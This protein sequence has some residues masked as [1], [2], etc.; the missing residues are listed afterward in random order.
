M[1]R[2]FTGIQQ[3]LACLDPA[4]S[5]LPAQLSSYCICVEEAPAL[6]W[7]HGGSGRAVYLW[8][9]QTHREVWIKTARTNQDLYSRFNYFLETDATLHL[10]DALKLLQEER[11]YQKLSDPEQQQQQALSSRGQRGAALHVLP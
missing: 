10:D 1:Q 9:S 5:G 7:P 11:D 4:R 3:S 6:E 8:K 2:T